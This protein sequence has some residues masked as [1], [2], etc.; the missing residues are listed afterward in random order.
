MNLL[1]W[2]TGNGD[3]IPS[4]NTTFSSEQNTFNTTLLST[5]IVVDEDICRQS[6]GYK[7]IFSNGGGQITIRS[8]HI[9]CLPGI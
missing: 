4:Q 1:M 8:L 6:A 2:Q 3:L 9:H 7:C 5:L